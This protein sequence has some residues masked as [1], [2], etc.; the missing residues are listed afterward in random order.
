MSVDAVAVGAEPSM[1]R[2]RS[3][4]T[5]V[6]RFVGRSISKTAVIIGYA[7]A[8]Y[9][10][11][12]ILGFTKTYGTQAARETLARLFGNNP[13]LHA[14]FGISHSIDTVRGFTAWRTLGVLTIVGAI[15]ALMAATK[16][17]R[18]EEEA[19][20]WELFLSGQTTSRQG[21]VNIMAGLGVGL[22]IIYVI[23]AIVTGIIGNM[24]KLHFSAG[25]TLFF[26]L[27]L[28]ASTAEFFAVGAFASQIAPTRRRAAGIAA[29]VFGVSFLLRAI[30]DAAPS[31]HWLTN[32]SPLG[33][34]E[35]LR[36]LTGSDPFWL[37]PIF[38]FVA[39]LCVLTA[40]MAG[41]RDLGAS[42]IPDRDTA[43]PRTRFLNAPFGLA[44]RELRGT[45]VGW[46]VALAGAAMAMGAI[47]KAAGKAMAASTSTQS[48]F[49]DFTRNQK[50]GAATYMG[51]VFLM[52]MVAIMA[53]AASS[54]NSMREDEAEGYLDNLLTGPVSRLRWLGG[55]LLIVVASVVLA[56]VVSGL[57][58][59]F[60]AAIQNTGISLGKL[61]EA[62]LNAAV[63]AAVMI[64]IGMLTLGFRPRWTSAVLYTVIGW[65]FLLELIGPAINLNHW[66]LDTSLLHHTALAPAVDPRWSTAGII[67]AIGVA[68][69][70]IG[71]A[72]FNRRDIAGK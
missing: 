31:V 26:S 21:A 32:I 43:R 57:F 16:R 15:W 54:I 20:R 68:A 58:G 39:A 13:G 30:G 27:A 46:F 10:A 38:G 4:G 65:S 23:V 55:R 48:F 49:K 6:A 22:V 37:L 7:F 72:A 56:G 52:L 19:G 45:L 69:S 62:G 66:L 42:L 33:W 34:I 25:E 53:L 50:V 59:W 17:F 63:P 44:I 60:G 35:H 18:G 14:L 2:L 47:A 41:A 9:V 8:L 11:S 12:S 3:P 67:I 36:P 24:N 70:V 28:V 51:V 61:I 40:Y 71:A 5:V 29:G 1:K 64:G